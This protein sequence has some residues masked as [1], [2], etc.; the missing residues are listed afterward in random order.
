MKVIDPEF[1][2]YHLRCVSY[3]GY[4]FQLKWSNLIY[5]YI[6]ALYCPLP[7]DNAGVLGSDSPPV[8]SPLC[9]ITMSPHNAAP[10]FTPALFRIKV[11]VI[12]P[13]P[14]PCS[15]Q[16]PVSPVPPV[17]PASSVLTIISMPGPLLQDNY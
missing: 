12:M 16:A 13:G 7:P 4:T 15:H 10:C 1:D 17:S 8:V 9:L 6:S 5:S 11:P 2:K 3:G 14:P